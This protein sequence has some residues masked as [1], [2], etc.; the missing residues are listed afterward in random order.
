MSIYD[1]DYFKQQGNP[2]FGQSPFNKGIRLN[3]GMTPVVKKLIIINIAVFVAMFLGK[4]MWPSFFSHFVVDKFGYV[5]GNAPS[6][7][8]KV[9]GLYNPYFFKKYFVWQL[10]TYQFVHGGFWHILF[11]MF[12]LYMIGKA[13][14]RQIGSKA[15]LK[16]YLLGG[17]FAGVINLM[18]NVLSDVPTVGASGAV[19]A[20]VAAFG[21]M[22]PNTPLTV[23][24]LF[25]PITMRA[26]TFVVGFA[27]ITV[28]FA[29]AGGGN[30]AHL[31]HLG[32]LV[33]GWM[34][35]YN[36]LG[37]H[38]LINSGGQYVSHGTAPFNW[39][40]WVEK[41]KRKFTKG[42]RL[43]KGQAFEEANFTDANYKK[44]ESEIDKILD[45]MSK[46]GIHSLSDKEWKILDKYKRNK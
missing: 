4:G 44:N 46:N 7:F 3:I 28:L 26:R 42:P 41:F 9:F 33:F 25:F 32:G 20:I 11:N 27:I 39:K 5:I 19:C 14:E 2:N 38:K 13:V 10:L 17:V 37:V 40:N 43:Y 31:A 12:T 36:I 30:I 22:N 18:S 35:V 8:D 29:L 1:R 23:L 24:I 15:F 6:Q 16:L 34:Y 45:K 21:L